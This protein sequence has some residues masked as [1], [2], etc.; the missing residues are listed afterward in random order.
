MS[1]PPLITRKATVK[2]SD[3]TAASNSI[4]SGQAAPFPRRMQLDA[5]QG[6]WPGQTSQGNCTF[7][8][9]LPFWSASQ[10]GAAGVYSRRGIYVTIKQLAQK[11]DKLQ[12][13]GIADESRNALKMVVL[14]HQH[15]ARGAEGRVIILY[16][17]F[18][19]TSPGGTQSKD[20]K[21]PGKELECRF[22]TIN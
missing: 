4:V 2:S 21:R 7:I 11:D 10:A 14:R 6:V 8:T 3:G 12:R 20:L 5:T 16:S 17:P 13:V 15:T 19:Q 9:P 1:E 18:V 22:A